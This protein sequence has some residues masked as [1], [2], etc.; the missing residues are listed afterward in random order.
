MTAKRDLKRRVRE[1]QVRTGESY[2]TAL[3]HVRNQR[4][5]AREGEDENE[6]EGEGAVPVVE[7]IDVSEIA[8]ALGIQCNV[9]LSPMIA[10]RI[11]VATVLRQLRDALA[12]TERDPAFALMRA[13]VRGEHPV[14]PLGSG[15]AHRR[16]MTRSEE[17]RVG[18]KRRYRW[19]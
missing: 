19:S 3:R 7:M 4:A 14:A 2:M 5:S 15:E 9:I 10:D 11:D 6:G 12:A 16:V 17:R 18:K 1:R 8:A 13:A